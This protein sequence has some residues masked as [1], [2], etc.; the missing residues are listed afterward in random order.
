M[1]YILCIFISY[2]LFI[3]PGPISLTIYRLKV[4]DATWRKSTFNIRLFVAFFDALRKM[5]LNYFSTF[6]FDE[7]MTDP[8]LHKW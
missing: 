8:R 3:L 6:D 7:I 2:F 4:C 5:V 1:A